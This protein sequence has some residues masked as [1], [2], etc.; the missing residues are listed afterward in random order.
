MV[1]P[2]GGGWSFQK[3]GR[4]D[5]AFVCLEGTN[6][7]VISAMDGEYR[8]IPVASL[9]ENDR[10]YLQ[11][12]AGVSESEVANIKLRVVAKK[13]EAGRKADVARIQG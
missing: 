10:I 9:S 1:S 6:V 12:A 7:V 5:A 4:V 3:N 11:T 13:R 8:L 2:S